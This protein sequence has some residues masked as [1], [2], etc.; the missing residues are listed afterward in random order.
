MTQERPAAPKPRLSL[1]W[2]VS[3]GVATI[4]GLASGAFLY[5]GMM[6]TGNDV[7]VSRAFRE[8]FTN[9]Y[10]WALLSPLV[11]LIARR[12][13]VDRRSWPLIGAI[14]L[15]VGCVVALAEIAITTV[16]ELWL[17]PTPGEG[18]GA[19]YHR[20]VLREFHFAYMIYWVLVAAG[21]AYMY[22]RQAE[23]AA[24][25]R[26]QLYQAQLEALQMQLHPHFLFNTLHTIATLTRAQQTDTA[27][28]M[29]GGLGTLLRKS[30]GPAGRNEVSLREEVSLLHLYLDIEKRRFQD[31]LRVTIDV[32][33]ETLDAQL[34]SLILQPLV[35]NAIR[36]GLGRNVGEGIV[37]VAAER[38]EGALCIEVRDD[39]PGFAA[40]PS[41]DGHHIGL[42]NARKR[43]ERLY[44]AAHRLEVG[45]RPGG[46][47]IVRLEIPWHTVPA[48]PPIRS[49]A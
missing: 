17:A 10:F 43:L 1:L 45:N 4:L 20:L 19:L 44:G 37:E 32:E 22:Y 14:H 9:W 48:H 12:L 16:T 36:H 15:V 21:H 7:T 31:R 29:L 13:R 24:E 33:A 41:D 8:G 27:V 2:G 42:A 39:G 34:P 35:E 40:P 49:I 3:F 23:E 6:S 46:G 5:Y 25:L 11:F 28:E 38:V 47:A 26:S 30:L 18:L